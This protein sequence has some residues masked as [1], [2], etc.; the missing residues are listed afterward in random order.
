LVA[1]THV[2]LLN[3]YG[4]ALAAYEKALAL[5]SSSAEAWLNYAASSPASSA[6]TKPSPALTKH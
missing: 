2:Y 1:P 3:R 4:D 6:T 5:K